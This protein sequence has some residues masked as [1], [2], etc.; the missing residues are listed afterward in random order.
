MLA[1]LDRIEILEREQAPPGVLLAELGA[2]VVEAEAW[3]SAECGGAG[4]AAGIVQRCREMIED[5]SRT[6]LA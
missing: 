4:I 1:R 3:V 2:L 5:T 6:L